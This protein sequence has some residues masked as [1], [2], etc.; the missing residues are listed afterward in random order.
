MDDILINK[1]PLYMIYED[2]YILSQYICY[3]QH[4]A[5]VEYR[6]FNWHQNI[7]EKQDRYLHVPDCHT[8]SAETERTD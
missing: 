8:Y 1:I 5:S 3:T 7:M 6:H 4:L 2:T